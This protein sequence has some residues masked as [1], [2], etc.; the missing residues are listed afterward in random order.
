MTTSS[1]VWIMIAIA[2]YLLIMIFI[3]AS[4]MKK[5]NN[6]EDYFLGGRSLNGFV[7]ALSAGASDM[8]AWS[9]MGLPASVYALGM[10]QTWI[11]IG[12]A[13]G[14]IGGALAAL[15]GF[16]AAKWYNVILLVAA[17]VI[18]ISGPS[19]LLA[20]L[21]LRKRNLGPVLN[22]NGWAINSKALVNVLFGKKLTS[23]AKYPKLKLKDPYAQ[24]TPWW[25]K[26]LR[27]LIVLL[28]VA[29]GVCYFTDNLKWM[30]IERKA[31]AEPVECVEEVPAEA[32]AETTE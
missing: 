3:G 22:A 29:F 13:I 14:A 7:A 30:G 26:C 8:S 17:V 15:G 32:A 16:V 31:K 19:M 1:L 11:A 2:V 9:L 28:V 10:G 21:K 20:W 12:L 5:N 25:R 23:V 6:S 27:W 24:R 18:F 4:F